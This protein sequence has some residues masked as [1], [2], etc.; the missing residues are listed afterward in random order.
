MFSQTEQDI[1]KVEISI[2]S[3]QLAVS[4]A[5]SLEQLMKNRAFKS[6]IMH[7]FME[8]NAVRLVHLKAAPQSEDP[9]EQAHIIKEMDAIGTLSTW[10]NTVRQLGVNAAYAIAQDEQ[11]LEALHRETLEQEEV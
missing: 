6:L 9:V 2:E 1:Q 8:K 10:L 3:A 11:T 4:M 5:A 7:H